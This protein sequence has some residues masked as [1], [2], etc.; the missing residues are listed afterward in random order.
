M[1]DGLISEFRGRENGNGEKETGS[2]QHVE[3]MPIRG[4]VNIEYFGG[5][6][7]RGEG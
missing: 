2:K 6:L 3:F 5:D 1:E 7:V 4:S